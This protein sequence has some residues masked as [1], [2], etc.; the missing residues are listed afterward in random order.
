MLHKLRSKFFLRSVK[1]QYMANYS[2][3]RWGNT[4]FVLKCLCSLQTRQ[5]FKKKNSYE[6]KIRMNHF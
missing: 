3:V 4:A 5:K 6:V 1:L 2:W